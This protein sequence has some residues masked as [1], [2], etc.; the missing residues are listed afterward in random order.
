MLT[1]LYECYRIV[2]VFLSLIF[3]RASLA[4]ASWSY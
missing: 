4:R 3:Y 2:G 1:W